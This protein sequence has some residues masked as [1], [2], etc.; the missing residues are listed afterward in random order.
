VFD[1]KH[2]PFK[3]FKDQSD[4]LAFFAQAQPIQ[5]LIVHC[6]FCLKIFGEFYQIKMSNLIS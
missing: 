4:A 6:L 5:E 1:K 2:K 3:K